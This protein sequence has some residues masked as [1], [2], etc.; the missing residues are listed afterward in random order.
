[1]MHFLG[2]MLVAMS[3]YWFFYRSGMVRVP[4]ATT[5][6]FLVATLLM[7]LIV[8]GLWEIFEY[9]TGL[10]YVLPGESYKVDTLCDMGMDTVGALVVYL[11]YRLKCWKEFI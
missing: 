3:G 2:G 5:R 9:C 6:N 8:G 10:T 1:M 11:Y 4:K 7:S